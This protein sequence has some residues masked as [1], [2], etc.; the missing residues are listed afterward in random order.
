MTIFAHDVKMF[1]Q[2]FEV[3]VQENPM[4]LS[5]DLLLRN[6]RT[7][8]AQHIRLAEEDPMTAFFVA[9]WGKVDELSVDRYGYA[10]YQVRKQTE[11]YKEQLR[12]KDSLIKQLDQQLE[13]L[14]SEHKKPEE[15]EYAYVEG[16]DEF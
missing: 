6:T 2:D 4:D 13:E 14:R 8:E 5:I 1:P 3:R 7:R 11:K 10:D 12:Q 9:V 16:W 15:E